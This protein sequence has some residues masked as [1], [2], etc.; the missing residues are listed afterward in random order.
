MFL[1]PLHLTHKNGFSEQFDVPQ[2]FGAFIMIF[3]NLS[4]FPESLEIAFK[5]KN[6]RKKMNQTES[7]KVSM[8]G[9]DTK[10]QGAE[11]SRE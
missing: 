6:E 5:K 1:F 4:P 10:V 9:S 11:R 7:L 8:N 3:S 2:I